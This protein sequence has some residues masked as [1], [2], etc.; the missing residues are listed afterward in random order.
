MFPWVKD[1]WFR[2]REIYMGP[3]P[4]QALLLHG[5]D[6]L[7]KKEIALELGRLFL[8]EDASVSGYCGK[9]HSCN[10]TLSGNHPD[11]YSVAVPPRSRIG[12]DAVR[13]VTAAIVST[14][15][16]GWGK[17]VIIENAEMMTLEAANALLKALEEPQGRTLFVLTSDHTE[18]LLPT[19]ISRCVPFRI[20]NPEFAAVRSWIYENLSG[21][22]AD[23]TEAV[24]QINHCSP[25]ETVRFFRDGYG[26]LFGNMTL[27]VAQIMREPDRLMQLLDLITEIS[28]KIQTAE[29]ERTAA[30]END[31]AT[32]KKTYRL[33]VGDVADWIVHML[34]DV[35]RF[36]TTGSLKWNLVIRS[37]Q[38]MDFFEH[39]SVGCLD[40]GILR[41]QDMVR[42][43]R[44]MV[45][46]QAYLELAD[47]FNMLIRGE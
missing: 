26:E 11:L 44:S 2:L 31:K 33:C 19:I 42:R 35:L 25:V 47:F 36:R 9:C 3:R 43:E 32:K 7:G 41:L 4:P 34:M 46:T 38:M 28:V 45:N 15:K 13:E 27:A 21:T 17:A 5:G 30:Q 29:A 24:Y 40:R 37:P 20:P 14:P 1:S 12:I 39:I 10:L 16:L 22:N 23:L 8:C 6:G 18:M